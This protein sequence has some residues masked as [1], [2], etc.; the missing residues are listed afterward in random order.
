MDERV[1][2]NVSKGGDKMDEQTP[3][4]IVIKLNGVNQDGKWEEKPPNKTKKKKEIDVHEWEEKRELEKEVAAAKEK[5]DDEDFAWVLP[6]DPKVVINE[7]KKQKNKKRPL[8]YR[9]SVSR[10]PKKG[11]VKQVIAIIALAIIIGIG[12][13]TAAIQLISK[14]PAQPVN[15]SFQPPQSHEGSETEQKPPSA[16]G[17][18]A[19]T[20]PIY[21]LQEGIYSK[22][23]GAETV[24]KSLTESGFAAAKFASDKGYYVFVGISPSNEIGKELKQLIIGEGIREELYD[25]QVTV[26]LTANDKIKNVIESLVELSASTLITPSAINADKKSELSKQL[27]SLPAPSAELKSIVDLLQAESITKE[28]LWEIQRNVL[29]YLSKNGKIKG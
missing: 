5:P 27:E 17:E 19:L 21:V 11:T 8:P 9:P 18:T 2:V 25:K 22:E 16:V 4:K 24:V 3:R 29:E 13:G 20:L 7:P 10:G 6:E 28:D 1:T 15:G 23:S 12:F 14:E 26:E